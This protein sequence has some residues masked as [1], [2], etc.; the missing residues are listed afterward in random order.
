M[1]YSEII[2][3]KYG[4]IALKGQNKR[5]FE[6]V[7]VKNIKQRLSPLGEFRFQRAQSTLYITPQDSTTIEPALERIGKVFGIAAYCRAL[8]LPKD[9]EEI[10]VAAQE[11]AKVEL[12]GIST[13]KVEA[14][15]SD[16]NFP[17]NS[18]ELTRELGGAILESMPNLKVDV[19]NPEVVIT[20][21]IRDFAAYLHAKRLIGAR[22]LPVGTSGKALL[23]LSGGIDSPVAGYMMAKRGIE[24]GA[25]H[26]VS[27][28]YTSE[29]AQLKVERLCE[30]LTD[31]CGSILFYCVP[32]TDIQVAIRKH[33]PEELFTVIMRRMMMKIA[34]IIAYKNKYSA[35][36]TGESVAQVA[37][38]TLSAIACTDIASDIPVLRPVIGMDKVEII[39]IS[40]AIGTFDTSIEP[41]EDCCTVF[42]P[43]HPRTRPNIKEVLRA[44][45]NFDFQ[46][47]I[48][49]AAEDTQ[50]KIFN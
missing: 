28:P 35:L 13:F 31:Y 1:K 30:S 7:L 8:S 21:E 36:I 25:I 33:C 39:D 50:L 43:K 24:V 4:E 49:K 44:E 18:M 34:C 3:V 46:P 12:E 47:L 9:F 40:R 48:E 27:P 45:E 16:K 11:Y 20:V 6:D 23:L 42:T 29:R 2:L 10:R 15:R 37:S 14:K 22:G 41:Y 17:L 19:H 5:T 38:Q 26:F 32:F